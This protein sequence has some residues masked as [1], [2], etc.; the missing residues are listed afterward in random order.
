MTSRRK[1]VGLLFY[2]CLSLFVGCKDEVTQP[3]SNNLFQVEDK[4]EIANKI[5]TSSGGPVSGEDREA[6]T[7]VIVTAN[8]NAFTSENRIVIT[9]AKFKS[10]VHSQ[11]YNP[12][13]SLIGIAFDGSV[14]D[15]LLVSIECKIPKDMF[16]M[17]FAVNPSTGSL[18]ALP[19][20]TRTSLGVITQ[21]TKTTNIIVSWVKKEELYRDAQ[22]N[23]KPSLDNWEFSDA[24]TAVRT[25]GTTVGHTLSAYWYFRNQKS[26]RLYGAFQKINPVI[27]RLRESS[28]AQGHH[29]VAYLDSISGWNTA[30]IS[31]PAIYKQYQIPT[32]EQ[33]YLASAYAVLLTK[34]PQIIGIP[35]G[36]TIL[37]FILYRVYGGNMFISDPKYPSDDN[38]F[39][40]LWEGE[41]LL[42]E[43][44]TPFESKA[45]SFFGSTY[46]NEDEPISAWKKLEEGSIAKEIRMPYLL[47]MVDK[48]LY[49]I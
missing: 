41:Q 43:A 1:V 19:F 34:Q 42:Y 4:K 47:T 44:G 13:T 12:V 39:V 15:P 24:P 21:I 32:S 26:P 22:S 36:S 38:R 3:E 33:V 17:A 31:F 48:K 45:V 5:I 18:E 46:V 10:N 37:P 23:F 30:A 11:L 8:P 6:S 20:V 25:N 29:L 40:Q 2:F 7:G 49:R 28:N 14:K 9:S 16:A 35:R 27:E